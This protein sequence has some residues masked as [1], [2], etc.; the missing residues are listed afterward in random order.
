MSKTSTA[1][2]TAKQIND[3]IDLLK[4][5]PIHGLKVIA[6]REIDLS[7]I[8]KDKSNPGGDEFSRRYEK[9]A[10]DI[11]ESFDIIGGVVY[12]L[13][14]CEKPGE[15]G[16][17]L[18]IDGHGRRD[19]AKRRGVKKMRAIV[20]QALTLEQRICLRQVLNAAQEPFDTPLVLRDLHLLAKERGLDIRNANDLKSL[21]SDLPAR[22]RK[23]E[24]KL[25][26]LSKWPVEVADRIGVD[27]DDK[28]GVIGFD[29]VKELNA[30]VN[31]VQ[32]SHPDTSKA[33]PGDKLYKQALKLYFDGKFRDGRRSQDTI[34]DAR[35]LLKKLPENHP[36]AK[37]FIGGDMEFTQF[38][39]EAERNIPERSAK[40][41][42]V[43][44][45][46]ELTSLLTDADV[47]NLTVVERRALKRTADLASQVLSEE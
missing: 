40:H 10:P 43:E 47:R 35:G 22:I 30:L 6:E 11:R 26:I 16:R 8:D 5:S 21:L 15:S 4:L 13:V 23:H 38:K 33:F 39:A 46:K 17:Y 18:I 25:K 34:R 3:Q 32:R 14:L 36:A 12:P 44:V 42:L 41:G 7:L 1:T 24:D 20:F 37:K 28:A 45:C 27:D 19:E 9:R 29:K 31:G 2:S